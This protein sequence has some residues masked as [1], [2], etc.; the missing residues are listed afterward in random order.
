MIV[1]FEILG[2]SYFI[3]GQDEHSSAYFLM[4]SLLN[5]CETVITSPAVL[6]A[7]GVITLFASTFAIMYK[8][9]LAKRVVE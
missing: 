9:A 6:K 7:F 5:F 8:N 1:V 2:V 3:F 4:N